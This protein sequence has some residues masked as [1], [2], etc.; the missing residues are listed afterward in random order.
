MRRNQTRR[1]WLAG[2]AAALSG[3]CLSGTRL[4]RAAAASMAPTAPVSVARCKTYLKN[5]LLPTMS[6]MFD[7]I[8]GLG[9]IV[10]GK[11][12]G[13]KINLAT[14]ASRYR[15]GYLPSGDTHYTSPQVLATAV[16]LMGRAGARRIRMLESPCTLRQ[17]RWRSFSCRPIGNRVTS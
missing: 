13:V 16:H 12:V 15:V 1:E 10:K 14:G 5:E 8:G 11:T 7:R 9:R 6:T 2:T 3:I 4:N 17:T